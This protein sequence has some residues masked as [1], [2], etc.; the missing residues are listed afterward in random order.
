M[1]AEFRQ[2]A[3]VRSLGADHSPKQLFPA[4]KEAISEAER[5]ECKLDSVLLIPILQYIMTLFGS[6][7]VSCCMGQS[8]L[9]LV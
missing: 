6:Q 3:T 9:E 2:S 1:L 5:R 7:L 8:L 4:V